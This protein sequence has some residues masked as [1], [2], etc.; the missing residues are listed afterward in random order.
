MTCTYNCPSTWIRSIEIS[1]SGN[2]ECDGCGRQII[3]SRHH[4]IVCVLDTSYN[5]VDLCE[6]CCD[7]PEAYSKAGFHH[8]FSHT[9]VRSRS[10][11][12]AFE[13]KT[14]NA[15]ASNLSE[16]CKK[17]FRSLEKKRAA[18]KGRGFGK[19]AVVGAATG[20]ALEKDVKTQKSTPM[21][22]GAQPCC[23]DCGK[24]ITL[25]CWVCLECCKFPTQSPRLNFKGCLHTIVT[26]RYSCDACDEMSDH[27]RAHL[28]LRIHNSIKS[29][30]E[31]GKDIERQ[32]NN[33]KSTVV[34]QLRRVE[35]RVNDIALMVREAPV[36]AHNSDDD[37]KEN[38]TEK[39]D[40]EDSDAEE[41]DSHADLSDDDSSGDRLSNE[42]EA[43]EGDA[44]HQN[45]RMEKKGNDDT[46]IGDSYTNLMPTPESVPSANKALVQAEVIVSSEQ[47]QINISTR[48]STLEEKF[49]KM[50]QTLEGLENK[51]DEV[52]SALVHNHR[53]PHD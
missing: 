11:I 12:H 44:G 28:S 38:D 48:L 30:L 9:L 20:L 21:A 51:I 39:G 50:N 45:E 41:D 40:T 8:V 17:T 14:L 29:K 42:G 6:N 25:P 4:C 18:T 5:Q 16:L 32:L 31:V 19:G 35:K 24:E 1:L 37:A 43:D 23:K 3:F 22:K 53:P 2:I 46:V 33:I 26:I 47:P 10:R 52:L 49:E 15:V 7:M 13:A 27:S 36:G 34:S